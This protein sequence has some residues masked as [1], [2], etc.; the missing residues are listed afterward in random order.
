[1]SAQKL[2]PSGVLGGLA[3]F[4]GFSVLA[5]VLMT[6]MVT[7]AL[8][9]TITGPKAVTT[10]RRTRT[11]HG[12]ATGTVSRILYR[13]GKKGPFHLATG[14]TS[15]RFIAT[16]RHGSN[17]ITVRAVSDSPRKSRRASITVTRK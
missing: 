16:L 1:M 3:G 9:V 17:P 14:T 11:I 7:P 13:V 15:W 5:G 8:A 4:L 6:A 10:H 12:Q 2:K